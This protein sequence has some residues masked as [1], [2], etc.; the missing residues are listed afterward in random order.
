MA[1][2]LAPVLAPRLNGAP[3][4]FVGHSM[5]AWAAHHT[6]LALARTA[7]Q[8]PPPTLFV[9][10]CFPAPDLPMGSSR[11][12]TPCQGLSEEA[13][14]TE[15]RGWGINEAVLSTPHMWESFHAMIRADFHLFDECLPSEAT[16]LPCPVGAC[17]ATEDNRVTVDL[18]RGWQRFA[19]NGHFRVLPPAKGPHLFLL[20]DDLKAAWF[21]QSL[22]PELDAR[23][24][25]AP[26]MTPT[27]L[28]PPPD[29]SGTSADVAAPLESLSIAPPATDTASTQLSSLGQETSSTT[30]VAAVEV[31]W[32]LRI[33]CLHGFGGS[34]AILTKQTERL[35]ALVDEQVA[36]IPGTMIEWCFL[37]APDN[38]QWDPESYEAK[39]VTTFFPEGPHRQWMRREVVNSGDE[40]KS[41]SGASSASTDAATSNEKQEEYREW[42]GPL[43]FLIDH[44]EAQTLPYHGLLGFSQGSNLGTLLAAA[45]ECDKVPI[46]H[47]PLAF[48]APMCGSAFGWHKQWTK[49]SIVNPSWPSDA[50]LFEKPLRTPSLHFIG[51]GDPQKAASEALVQL[52]GSSAEV[53]SFGSGHKPPTQKA[54]ADAFAEFLLKLFE[55]N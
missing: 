34:G 35:R 24:F 20:D 16:A 50:L 33:L 30:P 45:L 43:A 8:L 40:N 14:K 3:Y 27:P 11:P 31:T 39:L 36:S 37:T 18:V 53:V 42:A 44:L 48:V 49:A 7:P 19:A 47:P 29:S 15:C 10:V 13:F 1:A 17:W 52:Y 46:R 38:V 32:P 54:A 28:P 5:G 4:A 12:W 23:A 6:I 21:I 41:S 22:I 55:G 26:D 2:Q 9:P 51:S 25:A